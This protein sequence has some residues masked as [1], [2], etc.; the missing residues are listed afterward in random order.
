MQPHLE[1]RHVATD[2]FTYSVHAGRGPAS[3]IEDPMDSL[4]R[5][6]NDA[7]DSLEGYFREVRVSLDGHD[8]GSY[9]VERLTRHTDDLA[10]ELIG[11][12]GPAVAQAAGTTAAASFT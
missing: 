11:R 10:L 5:C 4:A 9:A 12:A 1:I 2:V 6:L 8:L 7:G 3:W